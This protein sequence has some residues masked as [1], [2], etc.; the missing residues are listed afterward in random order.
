MS[1]D[2]THRSNGRAVL[3]IVLLFLAIAIVRALAVSDAHDGDQPKQADYVLDIVA[4]DHWLVQHH[5]DG[6]VQSK[7]PLYNWFAAPFVLLFGPEDFWLKFPSLL[8]GLATALLVFDLAR[9]RLGDDAALAGTFF[10]LLSTT[11]ERQMFYA[12]TDMLLTCCIVAQFWAVTR[13]EE[14]NARGW[15][16]AFWL[17]AALGNLSKGSDCVAAACGARGTVAA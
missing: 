16:W 17:S 7:P 9:R 3:W 8:A 4:N 14:T 15:L 1:E 13:W 11:F 10:L 12:R 2:I 6:T 5:G